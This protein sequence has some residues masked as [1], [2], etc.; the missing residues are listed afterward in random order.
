MK[1]WSIAPILGLGLTAMNTTLAQA[2]PCMTVTITGSVGGPQAYQGNANAGTLVGYGD[3]ANNCSAVRLQ[4]DA[5]RGTLQ[6][7]SQIPVTSAQVNAVFFTHM[8]NDHSEGFIDLIQNRWHFFQR[9]RRSTSCAAMT[10]LP[11][12]V[13]RSAAVNLSNT[14]LMR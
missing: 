9:V 11:H 13:F 4:Y 14:L 10:H 5:G 3:D 1:T 12:S 6:R 2:A 7:L 8:H